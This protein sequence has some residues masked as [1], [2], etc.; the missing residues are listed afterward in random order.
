MATTEKLTHVSEINK[1]ISLGKEKGY[2]TYEE[3]NDVLPSNVVTPDQI[4]DLMHLFGENGIDIVDT[5]V[6]GEIVAAAKG[7]SDKEPRPPNPIP[8]PSTILFD[9]IYVKWEPFLCSLAR[10]KWKSPKEL[11][12]GKMKYS[13]QSPVVQSQPAKSSSWQTR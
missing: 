1:L 2:L 12:P 3:V 10:V 5:T 4:D 7:D 8:F 6:K 11:K 13:R 9:S